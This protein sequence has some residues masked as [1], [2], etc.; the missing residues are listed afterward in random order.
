MGVLLLLAPVGGCKLVG[1]K[2]SMSSTQSLFS[3]DQFYLTFQIHDK[4]SSPKLG[5]NPERDM[6]TDSTPPESVKPMV[7]N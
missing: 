4:S 2:E 5:N 1:A 3:S 6:A 7:K